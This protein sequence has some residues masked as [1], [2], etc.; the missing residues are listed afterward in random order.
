MRTLISAQETGAGSGLVA[1]TLKKPPKKNTAAAT[2][3]TIP[4]KP[5]KASSRMDASRFEQFQGRIVGQ[6]ASTASGSRAGLPCGACARLSSRRHGATHA[7]PR[8]ASLL[9]LLVHQRP[10]AGHGARVGQHLVP[11]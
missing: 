6:S 8:R 2:A 11:P 10:C 4:T 3:T 9:F 7:S 1:A 5:M